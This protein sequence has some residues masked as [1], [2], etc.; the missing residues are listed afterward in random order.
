METNIT[1]IVSPNDQAELLAQARPF[2]LPGERVEGIGRVL[3]WGELWLLIYDNCGHDQYFFRNQWNYRREQVERE[4][5]AYYATCA[6][7]HRPLVMTRQDQWY[8]APAI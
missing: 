4:V 7:C 3:E 1:R 5:R 8:E 2:E 6:A